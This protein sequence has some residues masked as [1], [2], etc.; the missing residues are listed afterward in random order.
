M[1]FSSDI[2]RIF[3]SCHFSLPVSATSSFL[4]ARSQCVLLPP[5][6]TEKKKK[7]TRRSPKI[8]VTVPR[9]TL[10]R[11]SQ[12][13]V[14]LVVVNNPT[15]HLQVNNPTQHLQGPTFAWAPDP[16]SIPYCISCSH[17]LG[18]CYHTIIS[19]ICT[20]HENKKTADFTKLLFP[21]LPVI[22]NLYEDWPYLLKSYFHLT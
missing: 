7:N 10:L 13:L 22:A 20:T 12:A 21:F 18:P 4:S 5:M 9:D 11:C 8:T 6:F 3:I 14:G 19:S 1:L 2:H 17:L 15:Q 16:I